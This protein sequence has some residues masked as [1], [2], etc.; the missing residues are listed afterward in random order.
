[1]NGIAGLLPIR[2]KQAG[3]ANLLSFRKRGN[4]ALSVWLYVL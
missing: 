1:M 2:K 4:P 3:A